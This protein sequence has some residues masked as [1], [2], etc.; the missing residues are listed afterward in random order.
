MEFNGWQLFLIC[1]FAGWG[2]T[3]FGGTMFMLYMRKRA[4]Q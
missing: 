4:K 1:F 2:V 3:D